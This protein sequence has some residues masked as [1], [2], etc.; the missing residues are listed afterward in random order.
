MFPY[1]AEGIRMARKQTW[2]DK[3]G[4][5]TFDKPDLNKRVLELKRSFDEINSLLGGLDKT[6]KN[7]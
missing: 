2:R 7:K 3:I 6:K 5:S 1:R 4:K